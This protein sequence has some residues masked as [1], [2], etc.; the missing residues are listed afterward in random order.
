MIKIHSF[1]L[2]CLSRLN[3]NETLCADFEARFCCP[4]IPA[5]E[6][7]YTTLY[8]TTTASFTNEQ[9]EPTASTSEYSTTSFSE[10]TEN[11]ESKRWSFE[12]FNLTEPESLNELRKFIQYRITDHKI[13]LKPR[14]DIFT[15]I[16]L[17]SK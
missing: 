1:R 12:D 17:N 9:F 6:W 8:E 13:L 10:I 5:T 7:S 2:L 3:P 16:L 14:S 4:A 15:S 11:Y